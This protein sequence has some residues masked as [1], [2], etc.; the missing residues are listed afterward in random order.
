MTVEEPP[1]HSSKPSVAAHSPTPPSTE[2]PGRFREAVALGIA[3]FGT[4]VALVS[5]AV[6]YGQ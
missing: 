1:Q 3:V 6:S 2:P 5:A 4:V